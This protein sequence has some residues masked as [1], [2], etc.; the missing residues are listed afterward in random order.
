MTT[1]QEIYY[2]NKLELVKKALE[3]N[4]FEASV[5]ETLEGA[6]E[7]LIGTIVPSGP[8]VSAAFGGSATVAASNIVARLRAIPGMEVIDRNDPALP[9]EERAALTRRSII[10]DLFVASSN[11]VTQD[12]QLVN[13]DKFG[14]RVAA[15]AYG[16][17]KVALF[18]GRNKIVPELQGA[19][20]RA[21]ATA[22]AMNAIRLKQDT[23]CARTAK[24]HDC[25]G[26]SRLC[27]VTVITQRS[28]PPGRIH[29]LLINQDLGF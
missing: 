5:H 14:N 16:P 4:Q 22:A 10:V 20:E 9:A 24:C 21:K 23:P 28:F 19:L 2:Q 8:H 18:V 12:G 1:P 17:K 26:A 6:E 3:A 11:A 13:I 25:H 15:I 27:G 29:V 7:Y